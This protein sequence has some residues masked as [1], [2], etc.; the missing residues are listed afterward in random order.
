ML[1]WGGRLRRVINSIVG[2]KAFKEI[3][4]TGGYCQDMHGKERT[5]RMVLTQR[6]KLL[7]PHTP[8]TAWESPRSQPASPHPQ[9]FSQFPQKS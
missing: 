2:A 8:H 5:Y 4:C 1:L 3:D 9:C 6:D 7:M